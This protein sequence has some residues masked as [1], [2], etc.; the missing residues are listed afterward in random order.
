MKKNIP[1]WTFNDKKIENKYLSKYDQ[2]IMGIIWMSLENLNLD[3]DEFRKYELVNCFFNKY[4]YDLV[5]MDE[6]EE[7]FSKLDLNV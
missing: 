1:K 6:E 4:F 7:I 5:L 2:Q 3:I